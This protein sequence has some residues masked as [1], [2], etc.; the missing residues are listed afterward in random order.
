LQTLTSKYASI[1]TVIFFVFFKHPLGNLVSLVPKGVGLRFKVHFILQRVVEVVVGSI[2]LLAVEVRVLSGHVVSGHV[3]SGVVVSSACFGLSGGTAHGALQGLELFYF[4]QFLGVLFVEISNMSKVLHVGECRRG[5]LIHF[6]PEVG[7]CQGVEGAAVGVVAVGECALQIAV[8]GVDSTH[9]LSQ[10]VE[11]QL[12]SRFCQFRAQLFI[13]SVNVFLGIPIF[14][15]GVVPHVTD[16]FE[17]L[18]G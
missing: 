14:Q 9:F 2:G 10:L 6:G 15:G 13:E 12:V 7:V 11:M 18:S 4:F 3:V 16:H 1:N 17:I 5:L 8:Q